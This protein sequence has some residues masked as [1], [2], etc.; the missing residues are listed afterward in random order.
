MSPFSDVRKA[1]E[2]SVGKAFG[3][4]AP[5]LP[6]TNVLCRRRPRDTKRG[7]EVSPRARRPLLYWIFFRAAFALRFVVSLLD[8]WSTVRSAPN[9]EP[10]L[11]SECACVRLLASDRHQVPD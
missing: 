1:K 4:K 6:S 5:K 2:T 9:S 3:A 11:D 8:L 10:G 7:R